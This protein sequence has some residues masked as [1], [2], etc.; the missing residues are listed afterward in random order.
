M[1]RA[2]KDRI[3]RLNT[4]KDEDEERGRESK[5]LISINYK[6][7]GCKKNIIRANQVQSHI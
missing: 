1:H 2:V 5:N 7:I 6:T 3:M 4:Q